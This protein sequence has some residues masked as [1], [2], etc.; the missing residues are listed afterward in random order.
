MS[1]AGEGDEE[2]LGDL[3]DLLL[4]RGS[5]EGDPTRETRRTRVSTLD[6]LRLYIQRETTTHFP[7]I[8]SFSTILA[9]A[10]KLGSPPLSSFPDFLAIV[11][12]SSSAASAPCQPPSLCSTP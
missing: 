12:N 6:L 5:K 7:L 8:Q 3:L 1:G 4:R 11:D 2:G 10:S 9:A